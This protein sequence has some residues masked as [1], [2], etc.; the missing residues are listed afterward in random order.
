[1]ALTVRNIRMRIETEDP[2]YYGQKKLK[3]QGRDLMHLPK[4]IFKLM[5]LEVLDLSP[6]REACLDFKLSSLP[7]EIGKLLNLTTLLLDTNEL[8]QVPVEITLLTNLERLTLSNNHLSE[9]PNGMRRLKKLTS[10]HLANNKFSKFPAEVCEITTLVFLDFSDNLLRTLPSAISKLTNLETL[11]LFINQLTRLPDSIVDLTNLRCL[12]LG[13]NHI[14][15]LPK[16]FGRLEKLDW[17]ERYTSSTLDG[18]PLD[19]PPLEIC[20]MGPEAI[21]QFQSGRYNS[22]AEK[23]KSKEQTKVERRNM[24]RLVSRDSSK[25]IQNS[26]GLQHN[27]SKSKHQGP[28]SNVETDRQQSREEIKGD[29]KE[30]G[31]LMSRD[32][33]NSINSNG[34]ETNKPKGRP[35]ADDSEYSSP[36]SEKNVSDIYSQKIPERRRK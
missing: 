34:S 14:R 36:V 13:N 16:G 3:I 22:D 11:L 35:H 25:S 27:K 17:K 6:E 29:R 8:L 9:L 18:N 1:M 21:E 15:A 7:A 12:W 28:V 30:K 26:D 10:L 23:P 24:S 4:A 19:N 5:E 20:R 31:R 2:M 33:S 32:S